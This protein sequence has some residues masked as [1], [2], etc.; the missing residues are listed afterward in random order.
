MKKLK[1][2]P[3]QRFLCRACGKKFTHNLGIERKR[4]TIEQIT[5]AVDLVFSGL[6]SRKTAR[7]LEMTGLKISHITIQNWV[8]QYAKLME[9]FVDGITPN[10]G[11]QWRTDELYIKIKGDRKYLF[12]MLDSETRFWLARM[13]SEHKGTDDVAPMFEKVKK[14]AGKIP[15]QFV[16]DGAANFAEAHK[17]QYAAKNFLHK[18]SEHVKHIHMAGDTNNNQMESFNGNTVRHREKVVRGLKTDDSA[19]LTGLRIYHNHVRPH[20]GLPGGQTP[21]EAAGIKIEGDNKWKT[22]IQAAAKQKSDD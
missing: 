6:S 8:A 10:V 22:L 20:Q 7:S 5:T 9:K 3:V 2:G 17:K 18:D 15:A 1:R 21:G 11:E 14:V 4:A 12:A 13:V 19:I 16:S